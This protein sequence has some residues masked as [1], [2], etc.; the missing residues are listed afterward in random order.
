VTEAQGH[1]DPGSRGQLTIADRVIDK[2]AGQAALD[3]A[4]VV[5][6]G[7]GL[8]TMVGRR[9]PRVSA[10]TRGDQTR[11]GVDIAVAWPR[12]AADVAS[13]VRAAVSDAVSEYAGLKVVAV[14]V[15]VTRVDPAR[16]AKKARV[17]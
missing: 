10:N 15:A 2:I 1:S 7:S 4:G 14:D 13:H 11:V 6:S 5:S 9:L 17:Q 3:V 8:D 12:S 16:S